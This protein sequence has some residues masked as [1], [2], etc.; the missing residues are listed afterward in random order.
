LNWRSQVELHTVLIK[1]ALACRRSAVITGDSLRRFE[2]EYRA[3]SDITLGAT[4]DFHV[5]DHSAVGQKSF[6]Q[7]VSI[8]D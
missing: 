8:V 4:I 2:S 1:P 3:S 6:A 7:R 5:I